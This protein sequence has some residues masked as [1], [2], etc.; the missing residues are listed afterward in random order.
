MY[1]FNM[2]DN[3]ITVEIKNP[4]ILILEVSVFKTK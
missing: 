2:Y 3:S 1:F 4:A